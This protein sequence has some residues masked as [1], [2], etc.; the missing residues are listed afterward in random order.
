[1][2]D[3]VCETPHPLPLVST[4]AE[5][6]L[7]PMDPEEGHEIL[8][9]SEEVSKWLE[10]FYKE[11]GREITLAYTT[12][13]QM[14]NWAMLATAAF[15]SA[16][17]ALSKDDVVGGHFE[18]KTAALIGAVITYVFNLRFFIR[19]I[20]CYINLVR[21]NTLQTDIIS[22]TL[23]QRAPRAGQQ[24]RTQ[25][26]LRA[27]LSEDIRNLLHGWLSPIDRKTQLLSN[28]KLGFALFLSIPLFFAIIGGVHL[29]SDPLARGLIVFAIG[30]TLVELTDFWRS[31]FFDT[32][33]KNRERQKQRSTFSEIF[34]VPVSKGGYFISWIIVIVA[35]LIVALWP[36]IAPLFHSC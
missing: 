36:K 31:T 29:W 10:T 1:M 20:L 15:F 16:V 26:E 7:P 34:P 8:G 4:P 24:P 19:A 9:T 12:L 28:L 33:N 35:S 14:K 2:K 27:K 22:L 11:C 5:Q 3:E 18:I 30:D 32:P 21:F 17:A 13:N 23:L 6:T 25:Q